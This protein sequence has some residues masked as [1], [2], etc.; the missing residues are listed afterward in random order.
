MVAGAG[1]DMVVVDVRSCVRMPR[2]QARHEA[3]RARIRNCSYGLKSHHYTGHCVL[4]LL[5]KRRLIASTTTRLLVSSFRHRSAVA[6]NLL[7]ES[8]PTLQA[9]ARL[10]RLLRRTVP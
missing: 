3:S 1:S 9:L 5:W 4:L 6:L 8:T 2:R 10:Y 7:S